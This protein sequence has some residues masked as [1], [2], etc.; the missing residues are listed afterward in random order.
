MKVVGIGRVGLRDQVHEDGLFLGLGIQQQLNVF[1]QV[2]PNL[3]FS[4]GVVLLLSGVNL[5]LDLLGG[6]VILFQRGLRLRV[7]RLGFVQR[8]QGLRLALTEF[9]GQLA[10]DLVQEELAAGQLQVLLRQRGT[11]LE[12]S[13][14]QGRGARHDL[15][16]IVDSQLLLELL[17]DARLV[18]LLQRRDLANFAVVQQLVGHSGLC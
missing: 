18:V 8:G 17:L 11:T 15:L 4:F 7:V 1:V 2:G 12:A 9:L 6:L 10:G 5:G 16:G 3:G 13:V 14:D